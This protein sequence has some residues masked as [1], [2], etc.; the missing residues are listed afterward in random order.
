MK[1]SLFYVIIFIV[2][3]N[4]KKYIKLLI[5]TLIFVMSIFSINQ[6]RTVKA[7]SGWDTSYDSSGSYD[8]SSSYRSSS[9]RNH[10]YTSSHNSS[11][12][13][14]KSHPNS[15][16][17]IDT[18]VIFI[19]LFIIYMR[20]NYKRSLL[21][22]IISLAIWLLIT[23]FVGLTMMSSISSLILIVS[24]PTFIILLGILPPIYSPTNY[25]MDISEEELHKY[26]SKS[27]KELKDEL[28]DK[29]VKIQYA[30]MNFDYDTLKKLCNNEIYNTYFEELEALKRKKQQNIM[31]KFN[32]LENKIIGISKEGKNTIIEC[33]LNVAFIDYIIDSKTNNLVRGSKGTK[34]NNQYE[35]KFI[36]SKNV[37]DTCPNCGGKIESG[38]ITC[39]HCK[40][41]IVQDSD[42]FVMSSKRRV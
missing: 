31:S 24:F 15:I 37:V 28:Y 9:S 19:M 18:I 6:I 10:N 8:S 25:R 20:I 22:I 17:I 23:H 29:F 40:A 16:F 33:F 12:Y 41:V 32:L 1:L 7:D 11:S 38:T 42:S 5:F 35:L 21:M 4:M 39:E 2:G 26:T 3:G 36:M 34:V 30:W 13:S 14:R 27:L